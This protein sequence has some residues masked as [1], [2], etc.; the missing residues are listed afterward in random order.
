MDY[1]D[2]PSRPSLAAIQVNRDQFF[3]SPE[4]QFRMSFDT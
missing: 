1:L 4:D 2:K 3:V